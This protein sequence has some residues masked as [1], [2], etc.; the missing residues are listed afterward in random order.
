MGFVFDN[1]CFRYVALNQLIF[2][3]LSQSIS[4]H[5]LFSQ[6]EVNCPLLSY[7]FE[8]LFYD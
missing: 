5:Q 2:C 8:G 4:T 7:V 1:L 6:K 3:I